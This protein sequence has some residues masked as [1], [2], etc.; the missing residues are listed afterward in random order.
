MKEN[1][2]RGATLR[3]IR[4]SQRATEEKATK[5]NIE[6]EGGGEF[7]YQAV[8]QLETW[9]VHQHMKHKKRRRITRQL[10]SVLTGSTG[11]VGE[12]CRSKRPH[13]TKR[14][15]KTRR[16]ATHKDKLSCWETKTRVLD[17]Q[18]APD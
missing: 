10:V 7:P 14:R 11:C 3:R 2:Q 16:E 15:R 4:R 9:P 12:C 8:K 5:G 6:V 13:Q 1:S 18:P 17:G